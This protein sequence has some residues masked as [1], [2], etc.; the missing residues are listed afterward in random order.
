MYICENRPHSVLSLINTLHLLPISL[1]ITA[2]VHTLAFVRWFPNLSLLRHFSCLHSIHFPA[3]I[4]PSL[5]VYKHMRQ[6]RFFHLR[7]SSTRQLPQALKSLQKHHL[8]IKAYPETL[9][10]HLTQQ[11]NFLLHP[12]SASLLCSLLFFLHYYH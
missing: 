7:F 5:F 9:S 8:L 10:P 4:L 12:E 6:L 3:A 1:R 11:P 2:K